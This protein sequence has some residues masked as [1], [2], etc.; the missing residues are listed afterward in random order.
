MPKLLVVLVVSLFAF[1]GCSKRGDSVLVNVGPTNG[2]CVDLLLSRSRALG[3]VETGVDRV[4]GFFRVAARTSST[5]KPHANLNMHPVYAV[6][7]NVQCQGSE[8]RVTAANAQGAYDHDR[9]MSAPLRRELDSYATNL[10]WRV[11]PG[12]AAVEQQQ[13]ATS[14]SGKTC[15]AEQLPEWQRASAAE[16]KA[17]LDRCRAATPPPPPPAP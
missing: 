16:K 6:H 1:A 13:P 14:A 4:N 8:A 12:Q 11:G 9:S 15:N 2:D 17:L 5:G 3:Y 10:G 7:F